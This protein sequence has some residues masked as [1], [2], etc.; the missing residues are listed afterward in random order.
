MSGAGIRG[1]VCVVDGYRCCPA[2]SDVYGLAAAVCVCCS[3]VLGLG[4]SR[5]ACCLF[6]LR[7]LNAAVRRF[8]L[9]Q[10]LGSAVRGFLSSFLVVWLFL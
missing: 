2:G 7:C 8:L 9:F 3:V 4:S 10:C 5:Q 6:L 1:F